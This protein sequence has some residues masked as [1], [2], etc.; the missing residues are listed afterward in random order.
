MLASFFDSIAL[1]LK[2]H[3]SVLR[4][5]P[6]ICWVITLHG[7][8]FMF[9][10]DF[11]KKGVFLRWQLGVLS[12]V[13]FGIFHRLD[14]RHNLLRSVANYTANYHCAKENRRLLLF[15]N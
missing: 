2:M 7:E 6:I 13:S 9:S 14:N 15:Y 1:E 8:A 11:R 3:T 5:Y 4:L 12:R 10:F